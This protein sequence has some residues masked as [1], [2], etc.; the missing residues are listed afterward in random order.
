MCKKFNWID[1]YE[2]FDSQILLFPYDRNESSRLEVIHYL[3]GG[4][5]ADLEDQG[6]RSTTGGGDGRRE[7][8]R[9]EERKREKDVNRGLSC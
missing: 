5:G 2:T 6:G 1:G 8:E 7:R 9:R 3:R 4:R